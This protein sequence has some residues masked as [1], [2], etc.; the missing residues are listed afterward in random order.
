MSTFRRILVSIGAPLV[1]LGGLA[2][3]WGVRNASQ[4]KAQIETWADSLEHSPNPVAME[5][6]F[7]PMYIAGDRVGKL[8]AVVVQRHEPGTVDSIRIAIAGNDQFDLSQFGDCQ[9][10]LDPDAFDRE[11]PMGFKHA[12]NCV[13]DTAGMVRFGSVVF[14]NA[15]REFA[16]YLN[17]DDLPCE[18]MSPD[19]AAECTQVKK[20]IQ[21]LRDEIREEIRLNIRR[22]VRIR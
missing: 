9:L 17:G 11:G 15:G 6:S 21:R 20:E 18:H 5:L 7:L 19:A 1:V 3:L 13:Q 14:E 4:L 10:H 16:L 12:L 22:D 2:L 8:D